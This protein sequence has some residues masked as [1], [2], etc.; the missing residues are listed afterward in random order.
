M[1]SITPPRTPASSR[2]TPATMMTEKSVITPL[3]LQCKGKGLCGKPCPLLARYSKHK[4]SMALIK[5]N[6]SASGIAP[7]IGRIGYPEINIGLLSP[8]DVKEDAWTLDAPDYWYSKRY[9]L[10]D[11]V[12]ARLQIINSREKGNQVKMAQAPTKHLEIAQELAL[13]TNTPDVEFWLSKKPFISF[14]LDLS[15]PPMGAF[16]ALKNAKL[17]ENAK[18]PRK[19]DRVVND[20][21]KANQQMTK[22]YEHGVDTNQLMRILSTGLLGE[23]KRKRLVPT[24]WAITATDDT[25]GKFLINEIKDCKWIDAYELYINEYLG[26]KFY[27]LLMPGVWQYELTEVWYGGSMWNPSS[28]INI[29][30]DFESNFGRTKYADSTMGGYYAA[31]IGA[32]EY[33]ARVRR[34]A[35]C[36]I[37][38][39]IFPTYSVPVGVWEIRENVRNAFF[40]KLTFATLQEALQE[41]KN[42]FKSPIDELLKTSKILTNYKQQSTLRKW[43]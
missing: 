32:L 41:I 36:M 33:L 34:Q 5:E 22:L 1:T 7:F 23:Q 29:S 18:I 8:P 6:F 3:C 25:I 39:E 27:V 19:V 37:M 9:E 4:T 26:N 2:V 21:L 42:Q 20:E 28:K 35:S 30:R 14:Q 13:S 16:G 43:F 40:N 17:E 10:D 31:R 11:I 12:D 38:R 24:R 15:A